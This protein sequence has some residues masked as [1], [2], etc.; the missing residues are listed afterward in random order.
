MQNKRI[1]A[2][3]LEMLDKAVTVACEMTGTVWSD[4][5]KA[6]VVKDLM[7]Y[8]TQDVLDAL[9]R[10]R[11]EL[12]GRLTLA[13]ILERIDT[14]FISADEAFGLLVEA[15]QN[16]ALTVVVPEIALQAMGMG[17]QGLLDMGDK[18]GARMAFKEAYNRLS[19]CLKAAGKNAEW[20]VSAGTDKLQMAAAVKDAVS[21]GRLSASHA[22]H[23]LPYEA[24]E[25]RHELQTGEPLS[26]EHKQAA[27]NHISQ[28]LAVLEKKMGMPTEPERKAREENRLARQRF[29]AAKNNVAGMRNAA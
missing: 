22:L 21:R 24:D 17:A 7:L 26:L 13:A 28:I 11:R 25:V 20:S 2:E 27:R 6:E 3:K 19:G 10:C 29:Q 23:A 5:V 16:E 1:L 8:G 14:G 4:S 18:T 12:T 9:N 15:A